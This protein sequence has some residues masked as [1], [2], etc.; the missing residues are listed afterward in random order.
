[1]AF[2]PICIIKHLDEMD[3]D[4]LHIKGGSSIM[5]VISWT[6]E[7]EHEQWT[8]TKRI[9][10]ILLLSIEYLENII[11]HM[12]QNIWW[13]RIIFYHL[14]M[15]EQYLWM[16]FWMNIGNIF[17]CEKLNQTNKVEKIYISLFLKIGHTKCSSHISLIWSP[18]SIPF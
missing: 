10:N 1:M 18:L 13:R 5:D 15:D 4:N 6:C 11:W 8:L 12:G 14:F 7:C 3:Y 9:L 17:F 2:L 16:N